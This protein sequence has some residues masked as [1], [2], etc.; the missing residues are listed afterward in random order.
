MKTILKF[1]GRGIPLALVSSLVLA[2]AVAYTAY[3][4]LNPATGLFGLNGT[5]FSTDTAGAN[6]PV[7]SGTCG[8]RGAQVGGSTSG[9][10]ISGAVTTCTTILT[11]PY[12]AKNFYVCA[13]QDITTGADTANLVNAT[14]TSS[15]CGTVAATIVSGD[16][17]G[18]TAIAH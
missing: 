10:V 13:F 14:P 15:T 5:L 4:G 11:F 7:V 12:A 17:I 2:A 1:L 6:L 3:S 8:T 9:S 16:K 18:W